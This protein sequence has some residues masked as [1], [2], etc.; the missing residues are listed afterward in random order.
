M[1]SLLYIDWNVD[2]VIFTIFGFSIR[3]YSLMW[4]AAILIGAKYYENC[5]RREGLDL[6]L[7]DSLFIYATL[8]LMLGAR[9]GH[10][11][12]YEPEYYLA[13][14]WTIITEFHKGG[15]ASHGA[16]IGFFIGAWLW[17]RRYSMPYIW[18]LD[19]IT[20][21]AGLGGALVR[22]GN[23]F[24]SEIFGTETTLPWGFKFL[25]SREWVENYAP[26]ACHP[27]QIYEA[28]CYLVAFGVVTVMY[29]RYDL[30]RRR[31]GAMF[32]AGLICIFLSR[33]L[34]EMIKNAQVGFEES[35]TFN[36]GQWLSVPFVLTGV[37][38]IYRAYKK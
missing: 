21:P 37:Y 8:G 3:Y 5:C 9:L 2:P 35:M 20:V 12:F 23:L 18:A 10:C 7:V 36:M 32:G 26:A 19:R 14:P 30:G 38:L 4:V 33:I 16:A 29:Y 31:P 11:L 1:M 25:R 28:I 27:T 13:R 34:I 15:L 22:I 17:S 24:N 6:Q